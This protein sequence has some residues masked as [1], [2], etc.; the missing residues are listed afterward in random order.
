M[1]VCEQNE[2]F[3]EE[4]GDLV[5][6]HTKIILREGDQYYYAITS[7]CYPSTSKV[8]LLELDL[9]P[10]LSSQIWPLFLTQFARAPKLLP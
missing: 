10:I 2:A 4:H 7:R 3:V 1:E 9:V 8:N 5:F 6:S